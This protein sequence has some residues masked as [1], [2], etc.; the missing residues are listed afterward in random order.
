VMNDDSINIIKLIQSV[1]NFAHSVKVAH[2]VNIDQTNHDENERDKEDDSLD[3][4][5]EMIENLLQETRQQIATNDDFAD[6]VNHVDHADYADQ[7]QEVI[8][9]NN[10]LILN[11]SRPKIRHDYK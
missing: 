6:L 7:S 5:I 3:H 10:L 2:E 4:A 11:Y 1:R 8:E 9:E